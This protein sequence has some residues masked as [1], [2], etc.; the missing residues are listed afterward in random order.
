VTKL[1][2]NDGVNPR[3]RK[4]Y[5]PQIT[6]TDQRQRDKDFYD[7]GRF[8]AGARDEDAIQAMEKL[9]KLKTEGKL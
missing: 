6:E 2:T 3:R 7:A 8:A 9:N 4:K 1:P 5:A